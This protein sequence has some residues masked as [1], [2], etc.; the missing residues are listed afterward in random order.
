MIK[1]FVNIFVDESV[2]MLAVKESLVNMLSV[3]ESFLKM[4]V[5]N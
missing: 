3:D 5:V 2:V 1:L 4:V